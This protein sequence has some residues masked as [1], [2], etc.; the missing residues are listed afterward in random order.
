MNAAWIFRALIAGVLII[1]AAQAPA[2]SELPTLAVLG[3]ELLQDHPDPGREADQQR[4]LGMIH[5]QM[6]EA[7]AQEGLYRIVDAAPAGALL[8]R[9]RGQHEFLYR[10]QGCKA[11][12]GAALGVDLVVVG[13]VQKVSNLILNINIEIRDVR[14]DRLVLTKSVDIRG[15]TDE[16]WTRGVRYMVR[17]MVE[18]RGRDPAYGMGSHGGAASSAATSRE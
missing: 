9:L 17:D 16:T 8:E 6:Q 13:W 1:T 18:R 7:L 3:F 2:R 10:C 15:N 14:E 4:R 12:A 5:A 11:E